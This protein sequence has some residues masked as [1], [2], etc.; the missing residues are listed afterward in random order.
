SSVRRARQLTWLCGEVRVVDIRGNVPTR[1]RKLIEHA[2]RGEWQ[3]I[4]LARAGLQRLGYYRPGMESVDFEGTRVR[5]HELDE[6]Q[7]LP[8]AGQGAVGLEILKE[9][10]ELRDILAQINHAPTFTRVRAE[11]AF[12]AA[13]GAGCQTP[14]GVRTWFEDGDATLAMEV[15]VFDEGQPQAEPFVALVRGPAEEPT[16]LAEQLMALK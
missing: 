5:V 6:T 12:L 13:L 16:R 3:G 14:V 9:N 7:F 10:G 4:L 8:A 1:I 11:R 15:R 2:A